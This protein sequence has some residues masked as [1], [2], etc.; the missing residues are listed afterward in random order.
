MRHTA[1]KYT[2]CQGST[3]PCA[4]TVSGA[5]AAYSGW[6]SRWA[7]SSSTR[8]DSGNSVSESNSR[9]YS[10]VAASTALL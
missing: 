9:M 4:S 8:L 10:P 6:A 1:G 2:A 7:T 3:T 5:A